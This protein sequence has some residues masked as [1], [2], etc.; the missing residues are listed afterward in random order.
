MDAVGD[1]V[2]TWQVGDQVAASVDVFAQRYNSAGTALGSQVEISS[3]A[4]GYQEIAMNAGGSYVI[5][6]A[7]STGIFAEQF[8]KSGVS[9]GPAFHV[10][11][12]VG[13][14]TGPA[15]AIDTAGDFVITWN[16]LTTVNNAKVLAQRF[17]AAGV[18]VSG[19][20]QVNPTTTPAFYYAFS[21]IAMDAAGDFVISWSVWTDHVDIDSQIFSPAGLAQ[22]GPVE[23]NVARDPQLFPSVA[24]DPKGDIVVAWTSFDAFGYDIYTQRYQADVAPVLQQI[25]TTPLNDAGSLP[26]PVTP[27]L[28]VF[29]F[30]S[31]NAAAPRRSRS[32]A[33]T[34]TVR[35]N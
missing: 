24:M 15:V 6:W 31:P 18:A 34:R 7:S 9:K 30:D 28:T 25:E 10:S 5:T 14:A 12:D 19:Q 33:T 1:F 16:S 2:I 11:N 8:N 27:T 26:V 13:F 4:S 17:N 29:D 23:V 21:T 3:L 20:F 35:I 22:G 32:R